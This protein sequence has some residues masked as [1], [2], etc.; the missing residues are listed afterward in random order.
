MIKKMKN[1][2][3]YSNY[4]LG[5]QTSYDFLND[6]KRLA[7]T[8]SRYKFVGK[9]FEKLNKVLE[10][11]A[12]DGFK[13]LIV[14][15]FCNNLTLSDVNK[16]N[17]IDFK[18]NYSGKKINYIIHNFEKKS[19]KKRFDGI[20][21]LDVLEHIS[22]K[23]ENKF[24]RNIKKSLSTNGTFI[25]GMPSKESQKYAS[26]LSKKHHIN[27]KTKKELSNLLKKH[28]NC[29]YMFS[30]NDEVLHTGFDHMSHYIIAIANS[31]K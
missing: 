16:K 7:I 22:K 11:G 20:Y 3:I 5:H 23:F 30:M 9:M 12:G 19:L 2:K 1:K 31:K 13:S 24:I 26:K 29:V 14:N 25:V 6:P 17:M 27:C 8:T 4:N 18:E 10:I 15:E 28:F 21:A